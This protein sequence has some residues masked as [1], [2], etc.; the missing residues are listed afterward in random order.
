MLAGTTAK[1]E[2]TDYHL[3]GDYLSYEP[4]APMYRKSD[5]EFGSVVEHAF[6]RM[7]ALGR[8]S[9][10]YKRWLVDRLPGGEVL[11]IPMS[12]GLTEIFRVEV[13]RISWH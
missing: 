8:W 1:P 4:Y 5:P 11:N 12:A 13:R 10:P 9:E 6:A 7:A 2:D 3:V